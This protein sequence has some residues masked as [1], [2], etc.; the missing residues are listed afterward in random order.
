MRSGPSFGAAR[1][2]EAIA[3]DLDDR[4]ARPRCTGDRAEELRGDAVWPRAARAHPARPRGRGGSRNAIRRCRRMLEE[5][6][7]EQPFSNTRHAANQTRHDRQDRR[8]AARARGDSSV[9]G[10]GCQDIESSPCDRATSRS[11]AQPVSVEAN[12]RR[13]SSTIGDSGR[14]TSAGTFM[15]RAIVSLDG[16]LQRGSSDSRSSWRDQIRWTRT[17]DNY[18]SVPAGWRD[19]RVTPPRSGRSRGT[20]GTGKTD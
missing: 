15:Q 3:R 16:R 14:L 13:T 1:F 11:W 20:A 8:Q 4:Q 19:P 18:C 2:H 7:R 10:S 12:A 5:R 9:S 6:D 17:S